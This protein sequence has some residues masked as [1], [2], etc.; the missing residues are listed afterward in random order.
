M[1]RLRYFTSPRRTGT[2]PEL[3]EVLG[4]VPLPGSRP[5]V[6]GS[7]EAAAVSEFVPLPA[8]G[9][10]AS[11][12][13]RVVDCRNLGV[14]V[15]PEGAQ[16][17]LYLLCPGCAAAVYVGDHDSVLLAVE[18]RVHHGKAGRA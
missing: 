18:Q 5:R 10:C 13:V 2:S 11:C 4:V 16:R 3:L 9:W 7:V 12:G 8:S 15:P 14:Y 6:S 17:F 1:G